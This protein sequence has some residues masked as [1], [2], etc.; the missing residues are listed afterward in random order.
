MYPDQK[1]KTAGDINWSSNT[2]W[3]CPSCTGCIYTKK[4]CTTASI[5]S[6]I[7]ANPSNAKEHDLFFLGPGANASV[8]TLEEVSKL[9]GA[10]DS[11]KALSHW[12]ARGRSLLE[13]LDDTQL[14]PDTSLV[15]SD[16]ARLETEETTSMCTLLPF[17]NI[18]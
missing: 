5:A 4:P 10:R 1:A 8:A 17:Y 14:W 18:P 11:C 16:G 9:D 3:A 12:F 7:F 2:E 6:P 13:E 15:D